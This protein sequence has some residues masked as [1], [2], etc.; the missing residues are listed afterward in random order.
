M[1]NNGVREKRGSW[2]DGGGQETENERR[3]GKPERAKEGKERVERGGL[4]MGGKEKDKGED[5]CVRQK[6]R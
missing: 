1:R 2:M 3:V 6:K 5:Y 4:Q